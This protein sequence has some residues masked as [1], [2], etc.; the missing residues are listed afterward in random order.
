MAPR[1]SALTEKLDAAPFPFTENE[2]FE[3]FRLVSE[4][5]EARANARKVIEQLSGEPHW[6]ASLETLAL[7]A[8]GSASAAEKVASIRQHMRPDRASWL[9]IEMHRVG[10]PANADPPAS[11]EAQ[12]VALREADERAWQE[13][14]AAVRKASPTPV[15][16]SGERD[17]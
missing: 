11:L 15:T 14:L 3:A 2:F 6:N 16:G 5:D 13:T 17:V 10:L 8:L 9:A 1:R 7:L 12:W 4:T